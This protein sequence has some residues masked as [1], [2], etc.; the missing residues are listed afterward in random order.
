M[1]AALIVVATCLTAGQSTASSIAGIWTGE[2]GGKTFVRL[3]LKA[4]GDA[5]SGGLSIGDVEVDDKGAL[6]TVGD[7]PA[8]LTP[9]FDVVRKGSTLTFSRKDS[10]DIDRFELR[11][12]DDGKRAELVFLLSEEDRKDLAA[13]GIVPPKPIVLT[14]R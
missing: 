7:L 2:F 4:A 14:R 3:E 13:E 8:K 1:T 11:V 9:I 5:I 12:L 10:T 6:K